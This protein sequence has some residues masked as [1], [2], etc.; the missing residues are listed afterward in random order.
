MTYLSLTWRPRNYY[1]MRNKTSGKKYVGQTTQDITK[2]C[3]SGRLWVLHCKKH[4]GHNK[5]NIEVLWHHFFICEKSAQMWLDQFA[6]NH[7]NYDSKLNEEWGNEC[8]ENT[9]DTPF[10]DGEIARRRVADGTHNWLDSDYQRQKALRMVAE[11]KN[12]FV[13]GE[14]QRQAQL[15]L[16]SQ[17]LHH[18]QQKDSPAAKRFADIS[19]GTVIVVDKNGATSRIKCEDYYNQS[20]P[21]DDW[22]FATN[23][24]REGL[25]RLAKVLS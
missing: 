6:I 3:G 14:M 19:R 25:K 18:T 2:Y 4:G 20:G 7:P 5:D 15:S 16:S 21:K 22:E 1:I 12:A 11:G 10:Q 17:G 8:L 24:S 23:R 9:E 13:G